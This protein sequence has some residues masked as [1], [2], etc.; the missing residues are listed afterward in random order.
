M[1]EL[2]VTTFAIQ[3]DSWIL[4]YEVNNYYKIIRLGSTQR[5]LLTGKHLHLEVGNISHTVD[6]PLKLC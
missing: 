6:G 3:H 4:V 5:I 2:H 1:V